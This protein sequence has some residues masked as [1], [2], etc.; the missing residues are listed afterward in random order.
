MME[1]RCPAT[2]QATPISLT[3]MN[4]RSNTLYAVSRPYKK[5]DDDKISYQNTITPESDNGCGWSFFTKSLVDG[6]ELVTDQINFHEDIYFIYAYTDELEADT[7]N[8]VV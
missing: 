8:E 2:I 3:A 7:S 1:L 4:T 5:P 6:S